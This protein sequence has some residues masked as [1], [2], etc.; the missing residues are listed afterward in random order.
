MGHRGSD[1]FVSVDEAVRGRGYESVLQPI[2]DLRISPAGEIW[3]LRGRIKDE[4]TII[5]IFSKTG[6]H[7]GTPAAGLTVSDRVR[8]NGPDPGDWNG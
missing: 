7:L 6:E 4:P 8:G 2:G 1:C 3:V 5:D